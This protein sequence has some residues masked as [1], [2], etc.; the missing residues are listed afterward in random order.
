VKTVGA[1]AWAAQCLV[2]FGCSPHQAAVPS[3][4][5]ASR[6][7]TPWREPPSVVLAPSEP[8]GE[9]VSLARVLADPQAM[10]R[11]AVAVAG[12]LHLEFEGNHFCLHRDDVDHLVITNCVGID[13]PEREDLQA[14][15]DRYV[16]LRGV[17]NARVKGHRGMLQATIEKV[18]RIDALPDRAAL[19][20]H[21]ESGGH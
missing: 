14:L 4:A 2:C 12:Y 21:F 16:I 8:S 10:D 19:L 15:S 5:S 13:V 17:V 6:T 11:K 1:I 9:H 7:P 20:E 18:S 3:V